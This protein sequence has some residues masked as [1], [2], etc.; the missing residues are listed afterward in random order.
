ME[1][2]GFNGYFRQVWTCRYFWWSLVQGD[3]RARYRRSLL[4]FGWSLLQP[5]ALALVLSTVFASVFDQD[6][7]DYGLFLIAGLFFWNYLA[8]VVNQGCLSL[9]QGESYIRQHP[10]PMAIYPLRTVLGA[11]IHF[12]VALSFLIIVCCIANGPEVLLALPSLIPTF[13]LLLVFGWALAALLGLANIYFH[14]TQHLAEVALQILFYATPII[15]P[16]DLFEKRNVAIWVVEANPLGSFVR[17]LRE[18]LLDG[19]IPG[20]EP[21]LIATTLTLITVGLAMFAFSRL[22]RRLIFHF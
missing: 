16:R 15:Y 21:Y 11:T 10:A 13:L 3:L 6:P 12:A 22:E 4:G 18:P 14:D 1:S 8:A 9:L 2:A 19:R 17:L 7:L 5:M 20:W